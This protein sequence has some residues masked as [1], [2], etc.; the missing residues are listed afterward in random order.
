M[1]ADADLQGAWQAGVE[2]VQGLDH[3]QARSYSPLGLIFMSRRITEVDQQSIAEMLSNVAVVALDHCGA[4]LLIGAYYLP[5]LF[6]VQLLRER[7]RAHQVTKQHGELAAL[8][9]GCTRACHW[10]SRGQALLC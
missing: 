10:R 6:G 7:G 3:L 5:Q 4:G 2:V 8:G 1:N 9:F